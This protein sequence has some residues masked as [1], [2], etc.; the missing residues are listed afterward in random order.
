M[1]YITMLCV[2][3]QGPDERNIRNLWLSSFLT[4]NQVCQGVD[5]FGHVSGYRIVLVHKGGIS[6]AAQRSAGSLVCW[7][8]S[9]AR[10][11]LA[12]AV[13]GFS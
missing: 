3:D 10:Y 12:E 1:A 8:S 11:Q 7:N 6:A 4:V 9:V 13:P 2:S 5:E